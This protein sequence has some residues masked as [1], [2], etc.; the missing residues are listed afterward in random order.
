MKPD[1]PKPP[2]PYAT[3]AA[4]TG[5][6]VATSVANTAMNLVNRKTPDGALTYDRTGT[7]RFTDP[8]SG[9]VYDL[10][11]Y[12]ATE[13]LSPQARERKTY[14]DAA[15]LNLAQTA[16]TASQKLENHIAGGL[17]TRQIERDFN[18]PRLREN[19]RKIN[20]EDNPDAPQ[21]DRM[22]RG[23]VPD[24]Q[25]SYVD[26]FSDDRRRVEDAIM[27]RLNEQFG[28]D[29]QALE[30]RLADQGITL[31][32]EAYT[33]AMRDFN[34]TRTRARTDAILAGGQEQSRLAGLARDQATF[35][36]TAGLQGQQAL[37]AALGFDN[38]AAQQEFGNEMSNLARTDRNAVQE[39]TFKGQKNDR[40]MADRAQR[41]NEEYAKR[42][43][44]INEISALLS[45]SQVSAPN[46]AVQRPQ[47]MPTTDVAGLVNQ[48]FAQQQANYANQMA[49][50]GDTVGGLFG[51]GSS[52]LY[53]RGQ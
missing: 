10:P 49:L 44:G 36:N 2:D 38:T 32:S 23:S 9:R 53:G 18:V 15:Q 48:N 27:G 8:N 30:Q 14:T 24:L 7:H 52:Y 37:M 34:D 50:Y 28:E 29:Q 39:Q 35:G 1:A 11:M 47:T 16:D 51:L 42:N 33:R 25:T 43:Q 20:Y 22:G 46:F 19:E 31:G 41:L 40:I 13:T 12:T 3:A 21:F 5:Q 4:Q 45:G 6:N 17:D 26:D